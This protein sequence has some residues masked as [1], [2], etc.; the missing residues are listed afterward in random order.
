MAISSLPESGLAGIDA[1]VFAI[2]ERSE[3]RL[4][5]LKAQATGLLVATLLV[6]A[7]TYWFVTRPLRNRIRI[8]RLLLEETKAAS[9]DRAAKLEQAILELHELR[10]EDSHRATAMANIMSDL[11]H[12]RSQLESSNHELEQFAYVASH[13]LK[14]PLRM[15]ANYT[16]LLEC[17]YADKLDDEARKYIGYATGGA[18]RMSALIDDLLNYSR[19]GRTDSP[20]EPVD[21]N[22]VLEQVTS[23][24]TGR[25]EELDALI[26]VR[27]TLPTV[28]G[29]GTRLAQLFQNLISNALKFRSADRRPQIEIRCAQRDSYWEI[30]VTDNGIGIEAEYFDR[31]FQVFQR[32]HTVDEYPGTGI[33]LAVCKKIVERHGGQLRVDSELDVGTTFYF[34]LPIH[35]ARSENPV[36]EA[37]LCCN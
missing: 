20:H 18:Q 4:R 9:D 37:Q 10:R 29:N 16:K 13:D 31:I 22:V 26:N 35:A 19:V 32:L 1:V 5:S 21:L 14:E 36:K 11:K 2:Q 25:I 6:L 24:L 8:E 34:E 30:S 23:D 33:G 27:S 17:E 7:A 28:L 12:E 3:K 15:V